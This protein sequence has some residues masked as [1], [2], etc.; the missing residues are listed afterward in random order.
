MKHIEV[1]SSLIKSH[2]FDPVEGTLELRFNCSGKE[3]CAG[4]GKHASGMDCVKCSGRGHNGT[5]AYPGVDAQT[6]GKF[7]DAES[8]GSAFGSLIRGKYKHVFTPG[9]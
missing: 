1:K 5:Y 2:A 4:S 6:Y 8:K 9:R 3:G 7:R